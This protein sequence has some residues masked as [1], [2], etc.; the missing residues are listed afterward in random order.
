L[1]PVSAGIEDALLAQ[2]M[3]SIAPSTP[4]AAA[5]SSPTS[6]AT[7]IRVPA[8]VVAPPAPSAA[9]PEAPPKPVTAAVA[10]AAEL[11]AL[12]T[13]CF[14]LMTG[15]D[16]TLWIALQEA[17]IRQILARTEAGAVY[18]AD[19]YARVTGR[20]T[21]VYGAYGPGAA[22]V[23]GSLAEPFWSSSPV[24]AMASAMRR[25][26]RHRMEYQE[27]DQPKMFEPVTKWAVE[28][29]DAKQLPRLMREAAR[30]SVSGTP[31]PI[32]LGV[33][34]DIYEDTIPGHTPPATLER[35]PEVPLT[36]PAPS[37]SDA[38]AAV[39]ALLQAKRPVILTGN[40]IHQSAAWRE[41][42]RFAELVRVPIVT[43]VAGKGSI[44]ENHPLALGTVGRYSRNYANAALKSADVV[45]AI[46]SRLGGMVTDSYKLISPSTHLIHV[47]VEADA[48]GLNFPTD[49]GLLADARAFLEMASDVATELSGDVTG[50]GEDRDAY[51]ST[52]DEQRA[53]WRRRRDELAST[54]VDGKLRPEAIMAALNSFMADDAIVC[55]DTGY[56]S[57]WPGGL[58]ELRRAGRNFFRADGTLG[59][60][61]AGALG[62]Q[63]A[64]PERQVFAVI[65]DGGFGYQV[66]EL[67]TAVRLNLPVVTIILNNRTLA[68]EA[69]VQTLLYDHLVPEVDDFVDVDYGLVA[70]S[71]GADGVR[72]TNIAQMREALATAIE[73]R[74]PTV[75]DAMI[76]V[77]AIAPVTRYDRV[78]TREL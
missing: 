72:V 64:A 36:R 11:K 66:G 13:E 44:P 29:A 22:N 76:D 14:F 7:S 21:F 12:G 59:W 24:V 70:R 51:L 31:G 2:P 1:T 75:I 18:M 48:I 32:Y 57:A 3:A 35:P 26:E 49:L 52:L 55:A 17:G 43:S 34:G 62:A 5:P 74:V 46:G 38:E 69:H 71:F 40:G 10:A 61:F 50:P 65:G 6:V 45:L 39:V 9:V 19:G 37:R 67:E 73:R 60:S 8:P 33:P 4:D 58:L 15:R 28:A 54:D 16:N 23:A 77:D 68:F 78:R 42:Q 27:L 56:A 47:T 20:P 25:T 53:E 41:L 63:L 30:R